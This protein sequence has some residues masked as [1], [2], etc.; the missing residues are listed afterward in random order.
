MLTIR[1]ATAAD[2]ASL[3]AL[4]QAGTGGAINRSPDFFARARLY[5][6]A[7]TYIAEKEG[8]IAGTIS[9][10]LK[11]M[12]VNGRE[13]L[14]SYLFDLDFHEPV[15][16]EAL[17]DRCRQDDAA[18][19][20]AFSYLQLLTGNPRFCGR[21]TAWGFTETARIWLSVL[22]PAP[23]GDS[24]LPAGVRTAVPDDYPEIAALLNGCYREHDFYVP[25]TAAE[26]VAVLS[27]IPGFTSE[28]FYVSE[29][30]GQITACLGCLD[31]RQVYRFFN[32]SR[33]ARPGQAGTPAS[34]HLPWLPQP[35]GSPWNGIVP[36][37][38]G[39]RNTVEELQPLWK[40]YSRFAADRRIMGL[41][42]FDQDDPLRSLTRYEAVTVTSSPMY[43]LARTYGDF[44]LPHS[45]RLVFADQR[46]L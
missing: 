12:V 5:E 29:A 17:L 2:N 24:G 32:Y 41:C 10:V 20:A 23:T 43:L 21:F 18:D 38:L 31:Y 42:R 46:D 15:Y 16:D 25:V 39:Y 44:P 19:G 1:E 45:G 30:D 3:I 13:V 36:F 9:R 14:A 40:V 8:G 11:K 33:G 6:G 28:N 22:N 7:T 37:P 26:L 4:V 27:G 35:D 34:Y